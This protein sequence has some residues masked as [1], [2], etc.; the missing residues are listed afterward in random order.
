MKY[1]ILYI[2]LLLSCFLS[3]KQHEEILPENNQN[4]SLNIKDIY[5][6]NEGTWQQNNASL[7]RFNIATSTIKDSYFEDLSKRKLGD[8]ANDMLLNSPHLFIVVNGSNTVEKID[9][10]TNISTQLSIVNFQTNKGR[11]PRRLFLHNNGDLYLSNFDGTVNIIDTASF[12]IS[13][14]IRTGKNPEGLLIA[15]EKLFVCNSGGLDFPNYDS[16][17]SV[18]STNP[19]ISLDTITIGINPSNIF[20]N[21]EGY[22]F[23]QSNGNYTNINPKLYIINSTTHQVEDIQNI[24][25]STSYQVGD[26]V[27]Y[28]NAA[29][30]SI[31]LY[32]LK[33]KSIVN[34]SVIILPFIETLTAI[35]IDTLSHTI[36]VGEGYNYVSRGKVYGYSYE[37]VEKLS[38]DTGVIPSKIKFTLNN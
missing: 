32:D 13:K 19:I 33:S 7:T 37:G 14:T 31:S 3:C 38:F 1:A 4:V 36:F 22:L 29:S 20:Q 30:K 23:V 26:S 5:V 9:L 6:L 2:A 27:F 35:S 24:S 18:I 25:L 11:S 10:N 15:N 34:N 12:T 16:T 21:S 17:V 8:V 28:Y